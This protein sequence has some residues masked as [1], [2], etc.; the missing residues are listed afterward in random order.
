MS[1]QPLDFDEA[2]KGLQ[3]GKDLSHQKLIVK[4]YPC[5]AMA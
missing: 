1:Q 2:L 4:Y 3:A 5:L